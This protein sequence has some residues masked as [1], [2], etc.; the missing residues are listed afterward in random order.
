M[1]IFSNLKNEE[2]NIIIL[3][4]EI[5]SLCKV[6]K[7]IHCHIEYRSVSLILNLSSGFFVHG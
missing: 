2:V 4:A 1:L 5:F 3:C 6:L 7:H